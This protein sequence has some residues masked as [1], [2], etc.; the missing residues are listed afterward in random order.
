MRLVALSDP[1]GGDSTPVRWRR[2]GAAAGTLFPAR[3]GGANTY[4]WGAIPPADVD[5][6]GKL[7]RGEE[8]ECN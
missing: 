4:N 2:P 3:S 7:T 8:N 6:A 5:C 1:L